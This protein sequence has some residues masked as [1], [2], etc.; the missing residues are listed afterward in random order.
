[1]DKLLHLLQESN[2]GCRIGGVFAGAVAYADDL[3]LM[4]ASSV[5][6]QLMLQICEEFGLTCDLK[7]NVAKSCIGCVS[8]TKQKLCTE[9]ILDNNVLPWVDKFKYL[10]V[11]FVVK[12][13]LQ[14][15]YA[16]RIQK[17]I[18]SVSLVLRMKTVGFEY[19]FVDI[20]VKKCLPIL[21]YGLDCCTLN[22]TVMKSVCR[23]WNM[24][25]KWL[26]NMRKYD[27]TRLLF[28][29]CNTMSMKFLIDVKIMQFYRLL[30]MSD[31]VLITKLL[32][33]NFTQRNKLFNAYGL[34]LDNVRSADIKRSAL[35][36][37][38][39]YCSEKL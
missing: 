12:N 17:F 39:D 1:M 33:L 35:N 14:T 4:S 16:E 37:F 8:K 15:D 3:I 21:F 23:A 10:G 29:S 32:T 28:L 18:A 5:K 6:L 34:Y 20:L 7:F 26:F 9:F 24:S 36:Q 31:N 11:T 25:F 30:T 22:N 19:M 2:L 38:I 27:S 13:G